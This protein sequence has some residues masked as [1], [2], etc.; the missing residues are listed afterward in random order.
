MFCFNSYQRTLKQVC[1]FLHFKDTALGFREAKGVTHDGTVR[2]L[3]DPSPL[4]TAIP[5]ALL[6]LRPSGPLDSAGTRPLIAPGTTCGVQGLGS[7]CPYPF[8]L[9]EG[10]RDFC[11]KHPGVQSDAFFVHFPRIQRQLRD[12][13]QLGEQALCQQTRTTRR[14]R[15]LKAVLFLMHKQAGSG[16]EAAPGQSRPDPQGGMAALPPSHPPCALGTHFYPH[17]PVEEKAGSDQTR[18]SSTH[19]TLKD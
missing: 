7:M 4:L 5:A 14:W 16:R 6:P 13:K 8:P 19:L 3:S 17:P 2:I 18:L 1:R 9:A 15:R 10:V 11:Q 12:A